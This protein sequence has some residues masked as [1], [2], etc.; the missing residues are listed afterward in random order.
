MIPSCPLEHARVHVF[1]ITDEFE[2]PPIPQIS[3]RKKQSPA[4]VNS[5]LPTTRIRALRPP[6]RLI[7][8]HAKTRA[9]CVP[10]DEDVAR[11][12]VLAAV[13]GNE[14]VKGGEGGAVLV[15]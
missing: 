4:L 3:A 2:Q 14:A 1:P 10:D 5:R 11:L 6:Y 9:M 12:R 7:H 13:R 8:K 15:C